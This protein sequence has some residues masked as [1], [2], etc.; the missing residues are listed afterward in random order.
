MKLTSGI[1]L[2]VAMMEKFKIPSM[3]LA[4]GMLPSEAD[5]KIEV[6]KK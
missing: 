4:R 6:T 3:P 1:D 5:T 2:L